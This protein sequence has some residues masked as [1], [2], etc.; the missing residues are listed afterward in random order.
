M[1]AQ[2]KE[3]RIFRQQVAAK[4]EQFGER[5][6]NL[7]DLAFFAASEGGRVENDAVVAALPFYFAAEKADRIV[8]DPADRRILQSVER[9]VFARPFDHA[10]RGI[11][12]TDFR[13]ALRGGQR[14]AAG[15]GEK[16]QHIHG[17]G[18]LFALLHSFADPFPHH[19]LFGENAEVAEVGGRKFKGDTGNGDFPVIGQVMAVMPAVAAL[20][21]EPGGDIA[22]D[23]FVKALLPCNLSGGAHQFHIAE[24]LQLAAVAAVDQFI[25]IIHRPYG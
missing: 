20:A 11:E 16:I 2:Q 7:E 25:I 3:R 13:T 22:P 6:L 1:T 14:R 10:F 12:M 19:S 24:A 15:V 4:I 9:S 17:A 21:V 8:D 5:V 18:L 23:F